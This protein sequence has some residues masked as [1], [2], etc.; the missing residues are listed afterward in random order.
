METKTVCLEDQIKAAAGK[1]VLHIIS[2]GN[3]LD[4][5]YSNRWKIPSSFLAE[6]WALVDKEKLKQRLAERIEEELASRIINSIA[7]EM[8]TDIKQIL[9]IP[10]RR[11]AIRSL[12]RENMDKICGR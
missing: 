4:V 11:E 8:A 5:D 9:S 10:E 12:A 3:W 2:S 6:A 7:T 1:A